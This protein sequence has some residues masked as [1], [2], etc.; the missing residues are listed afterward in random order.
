ML[1]ASG[2]VVQHPDGS[3]E[4]VSPEEAKKRL[5][6]MPDEIRALYEPIG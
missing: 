1:T 3:R 6:A 4:A 5:A 2:V